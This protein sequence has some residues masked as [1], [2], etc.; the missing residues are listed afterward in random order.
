MNCSTCK[1][2]KAY[3]DGTK[4]RGWCKAYSKPCS[5]AKLNCSRREPHGLAAEVEDLRSQLAQAQAQLKDAEEVWVEHCYCGRTWGEDCPRRCD[6]RYSCERMHA[7]LRGG[8]NMMLSLELAKRL[9][10]AGIEKELRA[11]DW[12]IP[13]EDT[14]PWVFREIGRASCRERV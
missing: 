2:T 5:T 9:K 3:H 6:Y 1:Y 4:L 14:K 12:F 7:A 13:W 8:G 10:E 11:G